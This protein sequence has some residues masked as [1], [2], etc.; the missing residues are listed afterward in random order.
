MNNETERLFLLELVAWIDKI[1]NKNLEYRNLH[2]KCQDFINE[3]S[4]ADEYYNQVFF[5]HFIKKEKMKILD[6]E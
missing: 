4:L 3:H 2:H 6:L 1:S 5:P